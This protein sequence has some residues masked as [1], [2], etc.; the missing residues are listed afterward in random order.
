MR[1]RHAFQRARHRRDMVAK[2]ARHVPEV[3]GPRCRQCNV[4]LITEQD[5]E[6]GYCYDCWGKLCDMNSDEI[7][8]FVQ[9]RFR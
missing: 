6:I 1:K 7:L 4:V 2:Y 3:S 5:Q 8:A 9:K